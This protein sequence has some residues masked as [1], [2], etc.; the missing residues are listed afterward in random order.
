[1]GSFLPLY[2]DHD[3]GTTTCWT[4]LGAWE[5]RRSAS[6]GALVPCHSYRNPNC[7][8]ICSTTVGTTS[9]RQVIPARAGWKEKD[10]D[11][12]GYDSHRGRP[13]RRP[14]RAMP[15][16]TS[17]LGPKLNTAR[18]REI[19]SCRWAGREED[20]ALAGS[21][22]SC[23]TVTRRKQSGQERCSTRNAPTRRDPSDKCIITGRP[24][25]QDGNGTDE[26]IADAEALTRGWRQ[27]LTVGVTGPDYDMTRASVV[28]VA[29]RPRRP[30]LSNSSRTGCGVVNDR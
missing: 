15:R 23:G 28:Q 11:E 3:G 1:M 18:P 22:P 2:G 29:R 25:V 19:R 21:T 13:A 6:E 5:E 10:Y 17:R 30:K 9:P 26:L 12:Y 20:A 27:L 16:I 7:W 14:R 24:G 4:M 8:P